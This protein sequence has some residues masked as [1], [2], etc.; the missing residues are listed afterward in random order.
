M[1]TTPPVVNGASGDPAASTAVPAGELAVSAGLPAFSPGGRA[2]AGRAG[3]P[4]LPLLV[5]ALIAAAVA[6]LPLIYLA[7]RASEGGPGRILD[8]LLRERTARLI[9]RS[10]ALA[11]TVT[12]L[13]VILGVTLAWLV[14]RTR[15]PGRRIWAVAIA[16]PL[17]VPSYVAA[18]AWL[19]IFPGFG[20]F[21]G[22]ALV[23]SLCC[24]PYVFLPVAAALHRVDPAQEEVARSL[25]R[26]PLQVFAAVTLRQVRP[27]AV[28]GGLLVALYALSDFGSV[29]LLRYDVFT[30]VIYTSYRSSFDRTPAAIL[31]SV[32]VVITVLIVWAESRTRGRATYARL[33]TG[34]ARH[35]APAPLRWWNVPALAWCTLVTALALGVPFGTMIYWLAS[36]QSAVID[37]AALATAAWSTIEV[38]VQGA[39]LTTVLA[40]PVGV[41]A[42]RYRGRLPRMLEQASYAGHALPG[43][44]VALAMVFLSVRYAYGLY[45]RTPVLV[46]AYAVLFLP[47]VVGAVR[48]SVAQAPPVLEEVARSLGRTPLGVLR[49]VTLPLAGPG[50]A[51]GAA[52][53]VLTCMKEL[54]ATL[55]LRP[56][57]ME[58]L[59][60]VMWDYTETGRY[61]AA[62]PY[63]AA[64]VVLA[65]LP[66]FLLGWRY[67]GL[68]PGGTR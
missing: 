64:L 27:A 20:G 53:T 32:L 65:A 1:T 39:L 11:G 66:T 51:A 22:S 17:A 31:A 14:V 60:T 62:A 48:A 35:R 68:R 59:A 4:P 15:L 2:R 46:L 25:G 47:A 16:L 54:P 29:A 45:Q 7:V 10:L 6:L 42:A 34:S 56:T 50:V 63:A 13:C 12:V 37:A 61:G 38:S 40:I 41:I 18:Y 55:L 23:L 36:R 28:A 24:Y 58:T 44:V 8:V 5:P 9:G 43:I 30:R 3:R 57:G 21:T 49:S 26:G 67:G 52:L 19:S 33:G